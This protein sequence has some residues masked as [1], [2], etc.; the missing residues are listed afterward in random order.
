METSSD[1]VGRGGGVLYFVLL[2]HC[3]GFM[4][5]IVHSIMTYVVQMIDKVLCQS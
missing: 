2:K 1:A 4:I 5:Q 3:S